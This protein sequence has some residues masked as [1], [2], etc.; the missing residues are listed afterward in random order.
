[1]IPKIF[2]GTLHSGEGDF[3]ACCESISAQINVEVTHKVISGLLEKEAHNALWT[4]WKEAQSSY[5]LFVKVDADSVLASRTILSDIANEL[6][7]SPEATELEA[8]LHDY[9][10]KDF[11]YGL[12]AYKSSVTFGETQDDLYCDRN[13]TSNN[14][15]VIRDFLPER[16]IPAALHCYFANELQGFH[17][18]VHRI[19]KGQQD[20]IRK[21]VTA[22]DHERDRIRGFALIGTLMAGRFKLSRSFNYAN[23]EFQQAYHEATHRY[24]E[25]IQAITEG[26]FSVIN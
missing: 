6:M 21:V 22:W 13:V 19:M 8:P 17:Y 5:D 2:V 3:D 1:M 16:L 12:H 10:T 18:G 25:F 4:A 11:I 26:R 14:Q 24:D 23:V 15:R 7:M 9:M 20:T